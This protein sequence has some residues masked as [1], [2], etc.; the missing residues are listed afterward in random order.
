MYYNIPPFIYA[1]VLLLAVACTFNACT[2]E[3]GEILDTQT[4]V[5]QAYLYAGQPVDSVRITQSYAYIRDDSTLRTLDDLQVQISD[6]THTYPLV[7]KGNGYYVQPDLIIASE[8]TYTLQ[9]N[10]N[11][12]TVSAQ[13]YVPS[14]REAAIS[15]PAVSMTKITSGSG[16]NPGSPEAVDPIDVSWSNP[17]NEYY[18]VVIKNL[19]ESPE[20][21]NDFLAEREQHFPGG[22][23]RFIF[24]GRPQISA[25]Y[26]IDPR[27]ELT[28]FGRY[29]V[30]VYRVNPEYAAL[31]AVSGSSSQSIT[32]PP[33]NVTNGLGIFT[34]VSSD[35]LYFEVKKK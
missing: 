32:Q 26:T 10:W 11:N 28:Q 4:A 22:F 8:K 13:T 18:Y 6:G 15:T 29:A 12:H 16:F 9:F 24:I 25:R 1:M 3:E 21:I 17:E 2:P 31:Y 23:R 30:M 7:S 33:T 20:Y 19:E 5:V 27:R 35:T 14:Q 34:G